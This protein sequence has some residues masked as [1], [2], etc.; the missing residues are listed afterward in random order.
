VCLFFSARIGKVPFRFS[1][2]A[3]RRPVAG[4]ATQQYAKITPLQKVAGKNGCGVTDIDSSHYLR[5]APRIHLWLLATALS[6]EVRQASG[7]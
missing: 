5:F 3:S 1:K 2:Q 4:R 7:Q 6:K